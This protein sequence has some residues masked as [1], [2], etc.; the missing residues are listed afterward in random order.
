MAYFPHYKIAVAVQFNTD[1]ENRFKLRPR[2]AIS[3]TLD[4]DHAALFDRQR[5]LALFE[6]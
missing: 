2:A 5:K 1:D 4:P 3:G 6:G